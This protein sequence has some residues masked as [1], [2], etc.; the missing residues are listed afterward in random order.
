M[1]EKLIY[2]APEVETIE[3]NVE[4]RLLDGSIEATRQS[5]GTAET[6]TWGD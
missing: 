1:K 5:Y 2:D 6:D 4:G 3:L